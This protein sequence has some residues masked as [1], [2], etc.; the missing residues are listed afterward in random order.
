M[1]DLARILD[2]EPNRQR[3]I[4]DAVTGD[5]IDDP[6]PS[7]MYGD[8]EE[9]DEETAAEM[10]DMPGFSNDD[11]EGDDDSD[12]DACNHPAGHHFIGKCGETRCLHCEKVVG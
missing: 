2:F 6:S 8:P 11:A 1:A 3:I 9:I 4:F 5:I 7:I 12:D 10:Q